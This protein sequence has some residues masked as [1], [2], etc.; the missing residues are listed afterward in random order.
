[1]LSENT[2][3]N[4]MGPFI[5]G[6]FPMVNTVVLHSLRLVESADL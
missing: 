5:L 4:G 6:F 1:M 2:S 3:L